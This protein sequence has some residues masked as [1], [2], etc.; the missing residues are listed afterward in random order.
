M[1]KRPRVLIGR[2][3][4]RPHGRCSRGRLGRKAEDRI[5]VRSLLGV[6]GEAGGIDVAGRLEQHREHGTVKRP[7]RAR[8]ERV[9][10]RDPRK[11][12]A[13]A[14]PA[15]VGAQHAGG[16]ALV[17]RRVR[18]RHKPVEQ[19]ALDRRRN[20]RDSVEQ[21]PGVLPKPCRTR[22]HGIAD[23]LGDAFA[24]CGKRLGDEERI[25][26]RPLVQNAGIDAGLGRE[27]P[28]QPRATAPRP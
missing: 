14:D 5:G 15:C 1:A 6:V 26:V 2:L 10:D 21:P 25:A 13:E 4:M 9:F 22:E 23:R 19:R 17:E 20:D 12:M 3:T 28:R 27:M 16:R 24:A 8:R 11:L 18:V 7:P